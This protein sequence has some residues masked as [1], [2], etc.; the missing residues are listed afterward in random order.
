MKAEERHELQQ[1]D[2][3]SWLQYGFP[4]WIKQ[5]GSYVLLAIALII[6]GFQLWNYMER[7]RQA[8]V[9]SAINE[10]V[11][12]AEPS[13]ENRIFKLQNI[14]DQNDSKPIRAIALRDLGNA[15]LLTVATG[16]SDD[17]LNTAPVDKEDALRRAEEAFTRIVNEFSDQKLALGGAKMGLAVIAENRGDWDGAKKQYEAIADDKGP[18]ANTPFAKE[19]AERIKNLDKSK[20]AP[21]LATLTPATAPATAP[22]TS[23]PSMIE[24]P[25]TRS[26][27]PR[28]P[29]FMLDPSQK[30]TSPDV[31]GS[32]SLVPPTT[33]APASTQPK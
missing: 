30:Y 2:L 10:L 19:A 18:F 7:N 11:S 16:K 23:L 21:R 12:L 14:V 8:K 3:K 20:N 33:T 31:P 26:E 22:A 25:T 28:A 24:P 17:P 15:Y 5:N 1:N 4:V 29:G 6:L 9:Q 32:G 27:A 13:T